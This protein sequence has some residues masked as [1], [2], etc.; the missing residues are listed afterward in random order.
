[1]HPLATAY[2]MLPG[3]LGQ[4]GGAP[5]T[6][7]PPDKSAVRCLGIFGSPGQ[8]WRKGQ[9]LSD[10]NI[11][12]VFVSHSELADDIIRRAHREGARVYAE[13]GVFMGPGTAEKY[14]ELWPLNEKG[15]RQEKDEWY[16][17]L[18]PNV[19]WYRDEKIELLRRFAAQHDID[20]IWLDFIR[21]P[22]HWEVHQPRLEQGCL[23]RACLAAFQKATGLKLP[24]GPVARQ[25]EL[26]L[27]KHR[28]EWTAFKCRTIFEF[29]RD[30][31][32]A[33]KEKRPNALLGAFVVPW[34]E[35]DYGDAIHEIIAQDFAQL[36]QV[37]DVFSPMSYHAMC[38]WP[39]EWVGQFNEYVTRKTGRDV[40]PIVQATEREGRYGDAPVDADAF[41]KVLT[42]GLSGGA[43]GVLM[44]RLADCT[45]DNGKLAVIR[46]VYGEFAR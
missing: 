10:Y 21:Y 12:A 17:G 44:F 31:R 4:P 39:I 15:Q 7:R 42:Q 6:V 26:L 34:T 3:L 24:P 30:A 19:A 16:L 36:A 25:A 11:N 40:W 20:G 28:A 43:T 1:M 13:F 27:E 23:N 8:L 18:C 9:R 32:R 33:L 41:R 37:L 45:E 2:L 14:P 29:C 22:G 38:G 5:V 35:S 46:D